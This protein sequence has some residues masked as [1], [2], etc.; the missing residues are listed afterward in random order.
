MRLF[1]FNLLADA[2]LTDPQAVKPSPNI[3]SDPLVDQ[4]AAL[5][6][7]IGAILIVLAIAAIVGFFSRKAE[8]AIF[9]GLV[10]SAIVISFFFISGR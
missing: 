3:Q 2:P 8:Y 6:V 9:T 10:L 5:T 1:L 7:H 4:G